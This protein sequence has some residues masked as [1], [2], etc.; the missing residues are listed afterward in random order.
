[1]NPRGQV[2]LKCTETVPTGSSANAMSCSSGSSMSGGTT[3]PVMTISPARSRSPKAASTSATWRTM[4]IHGPVL[5]CGSVVR[6]DS[7]LR[8]MMRQVRPSD[9]LPVRGGA[10]EHHAALVDVVAQDAL[11]VFG[12]LVQVDQLDGR[13]DASNGGCRGAVVGPACQIAP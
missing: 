5:A 4:S 12:R 10:A 6:A 7:A 3:E 9:A 2:R 1:M 8:R 11:D 13:R